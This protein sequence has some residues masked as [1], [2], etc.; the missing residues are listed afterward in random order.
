MPTLP[1]PEGRR[2]KRTA[3][4]K[5]ASVVVRH[6][7]QHERVPCIILDIS[8]GGFRLRGTTRFRRGQVVEVF[9]DEDPM[10]VQRCSVIWVG[11]PGSKNEGEVGL[12]VV[13]H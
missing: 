12:Q 7:I 8:Q 9:L 4:K 3:V 1:T 10:N 5:R 13:S 6:G 11:K 2:S